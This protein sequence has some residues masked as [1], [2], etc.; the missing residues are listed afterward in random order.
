MID[1]STMNLTMMRKALQTSIECK[2][3]EFTSVLD[4]LP[5]CE[6]IEPDLVLVDYM[7]PG[8]NGIDFIKKFRTL[9]GREATPILMVTTSDVREVRYRALESGATDFLNKPLDK[10]ELVA[11]CKNMLTIR[12]S[13]RFLQDRA[14]WLAEE[15]R[16]ATGEILAR[17]QEVILRL[18]KAAEF[19]DP[20]TGA[21]LIRMA[22]YSKLIARHLGL[23]ED[24][25]ELLHSAAPM[26]DVGKVGIADQILLKP[27]RLTDDEFRIMKRHA[28][29]GYEILTDSPS[30]LLQCA[31]EIALH[32]HEKVDGS[33]YPRGLK[34]QHIPI[35]GRIIAVA[36]VFDALT[37]ERTYKKAWSIDAARELLTK[38]TDSHFDRG[39]V[40][41]FFEC[42]Q[43]V[44]DI[45][46]RYK[47]PEPETPGYHG[48]IVH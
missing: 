33:G 24:Y 38:N 45:H 29:I 40:T 48:E 30:P 6:H 16:K 41:A 13:Q 31:A 36:D 32:H 23:A 9:P 20:E 12:Y 15:V 1:D 18:S 42:W 11:R 39:C 35:S 5:A 37:S 43:D 26:H 47:D 4:A 27:G 46:N 25:C 14:S 17:E 28:E 21:H 3:Y 10:T 34:D 7:M 44:I 2:I 22:A 8:L 19:R